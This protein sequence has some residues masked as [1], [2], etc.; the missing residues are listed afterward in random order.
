[1]TISAFHFSKLPGTPTGKE[2]LYALYAVKD[3]CKIGESTL[4]IE[5]N[6]LSKKEG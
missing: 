2:H 6:Y 5:L 4:I 1:M 3:L